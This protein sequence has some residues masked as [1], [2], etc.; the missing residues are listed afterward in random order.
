MINHL[1][2]K[3]NL[4]APR[5]R[6]EV[7]NVLDEEFFEMFYDKFPKHK[8]L[9]ETQIR[10]IIDSVNTL[11]WKTAIKER[12]G[13]EFPEG[14]GYIFL[15]SCK[16]SKMFSTDYG[17]SLKNDVRFKNYNWESD[18]HMLKI[19]YSNFSTKYSFENRNLWVFESSR[20]F[21]REASSVYRN[22][23]KKYVQVEDHRKISSMFRN[24][25]KT[26]S[27]N[28]KK[29]DIPDNYDEF[30]LID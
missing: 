4:N 3:P 23:W 14:L 15:G 7:K 13:V 20:N 6:K 27:I 29:R 28:N 2:K 24:Y 21:S 25:I 30:D 5:Y 11:I 9:S 17:K 19:F 22:E 12:D 10:K 18:N 8:N 16:Q 1:I 26:Q